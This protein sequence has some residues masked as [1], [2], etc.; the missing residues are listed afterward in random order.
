MSALGGP[1]QQL[2]PTLTPLPSYVPLV[3][4]ATLAYWS[5]GLLT[6]AGLVLQVGPNRFQQYSLASQWLAASLLK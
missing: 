6:E 4:A 1:Q 5:E 3:W 2:L